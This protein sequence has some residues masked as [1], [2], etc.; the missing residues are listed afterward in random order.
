MTREEYI[1][2]LKIAAPHI[3]EN[4]GVRS[5][6]MFG[7]IAR[8][9]GTEESDI[10]LF[11][12]MPAKAFLLVRLGNY[13]E[14]LLGKSVDLVLKKKDMRPFFINEIKRDGITIF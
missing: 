9:T 7:S 10:D 5:M 14:N 13:L 11:I 3:K 8:G 1:D 4:F 6:S 2:K 12:D